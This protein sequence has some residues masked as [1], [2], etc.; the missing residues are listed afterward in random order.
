MLS[1]VADPR[2]EECDGGQNSSVENQEKVSPINSESFSDPQAS[3]D[4]ET[5][6]KRKVLDSLPSYIQILLEFIGIHDDDILILCK[7]N[8]ELVSQLNEAAQRLHQIA[9]TSEIGKRFVCELKANSQE[10][11]HFKIRKG[12][13][14]MISMAR[15]KIKEEVKSYENCCQQVQKSCCFEIPLSSYDDDHSR[16]S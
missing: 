13:E 10:F 2:L 3:I 4:D 8:D 14:K 12:H 7:F 1:R 16:F 11:E 15:K 9:D 5:E 6:R